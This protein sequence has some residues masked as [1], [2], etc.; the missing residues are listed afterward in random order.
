MCRRAVSLHGLMARKCLLVGW[1]CCGGFLFQSISGNKGHRQDGADVVSSERL[2]FC[3][4]AD[5]VAGW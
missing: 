1:G 3:A 4:V 5:A 2:V